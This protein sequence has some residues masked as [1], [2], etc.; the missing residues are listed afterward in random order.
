LEA[1]PKVY[2]AGP[3][4]MTTTLDNHLKRSFK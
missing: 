4:V 3:E 2:R 1:L